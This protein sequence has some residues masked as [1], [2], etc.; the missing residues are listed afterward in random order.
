MSSFLVFGVIGDDNRCLTKIG[1]LLYVCINSV[2]YLQCV[3]EL[4]LFIF[5]MAC[6]QSTP[7]VLHFNVFILYIP[8]KKTLLFC[9][10][11][12]RQFFIIMKMYGER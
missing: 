4:V 12:H 6:E 8:I 5:C 10:Q 11:L 3:I 2:G 1:K 9:I 7:R